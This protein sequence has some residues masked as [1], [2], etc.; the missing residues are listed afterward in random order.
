MFHF[1]QLTSNEKADSDRSKV[2]DPCRD[3]HHHDAKTLEKI[4]DW[5]GVLTGDGDCDSCRDAEDNEAKLG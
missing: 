4:Q 2:D 1:K 3:P 5:L